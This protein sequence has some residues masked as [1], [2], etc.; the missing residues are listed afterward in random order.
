[1]SRRKRRGDDTAPALFPFLAVLLC[2]IGALILILAITVTNSHASARRD[3]E[4]ALTAIEDTSDMVE[5]VSDE[6]LAQREQLKNKVERRRRDL[7]DVEDHILRLSQSLQE[8]KDKARLLEQESNDN[9]IDLDDKAE[10]IASLRNEIDSKRKELLDE[11]EKQKKRKPAFS[12]IPYT[13]ANGTSRRPIYL[14][15]TNDGV[16][17]QPEGILISL[18]D[19]QPPLGPGNPLDAALRLLRT[20]YQQ[21]DVTFGVTKPPYPLL[22]VRPDGIRANAFA[23]E[24]MTGWDDQFGYELVSAE[25]ELKFPASIP[26]L[27]E[28]LA[29]TIEA[30]KKRQQALIAASPRSRFPS[31]MDWDAIDAVAA[32]GNGGFGGSQ[33][34]NG[35]SGETSNGHSMAANGTARGTQGSVPSGMGNF[36]GGEESASSSGSEPPSQTSA[37]ASGM[38]GQPVQEWQMVQ[39]IANSQVSNTIQR[40]GNNFEIRPPDGEGNGKTMKVGGTTPE[41][42]EPMPFEIGSGATTF[43][44]SAAGAMASNSQPTGASLGSAS[45]QSFNPA[46]GSSVASSQGG[47]GS[48][49]SGSR[50]PNGQNTTPTSGSMAMSSGSATGTPADSVAQDARGQVP[51]TATVNVTPPSST[52][53]KHV[54]PDG[55]LKPISVTAGRGWAASRADGKATPVTRTMNMVVLKDRWLLRSES[56]GN[57]SAFDANITMAEGPQKAGDELAIAMRRRVDSWGLSVPGGYWSPSLT[58]EAASDSQ[59]SVARLQKLLEGSGV[60]SYVVPLTI[61]TRR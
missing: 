61:P 36:Q 60:D 24:A 38:S 45:P 18:S 1:M 13:G 17:I 54:N 21:R 9:D 44:N 29:E 7:S 11:I 28:K 5:V 58:L 22:I 19:L 40:N 37:F 50:Q 25:M 31:E 30:A 57:D 10:R 6:L 34:S 3:A 56:N 32:Q 4:K 43:G 39:G 8:L 55:D 49:A 15:C 12:I 35:A 26:G 51:T 14:E 33:G 20:T 46:S 48:A 27:K 23:R 16:V 59:Q 47:S 52:K 53:A 42:R 2:T 41:G